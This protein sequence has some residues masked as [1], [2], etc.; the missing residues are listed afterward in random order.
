MPVAIVNGLVRKYVYQ[1]WVGEL[2]AHQISSV[3]AVGLFLLLMSWFYGKNKKLF[4][5]G[6]TVKVGSL[7]L[8]MTIL[9]EFGFGHYLMGNSWGR[10]LHDYNVFEGRLWLLVLLTTWW[11]LWGIER[12]KRMK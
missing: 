11:G 12:L 7:W 9:F 2:V 10:L 8:G 6:D 4:K 5:K 3:V 1:V